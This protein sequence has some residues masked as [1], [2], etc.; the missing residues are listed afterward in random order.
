MGEIHKLLTEHGKAKVVQMD[1]DR[2]VIDAATHY[3]GI[4][5][6]EIGF[7]YS[8]WAQSAL[9][10]KKLADEASW[11]VRTDY[12]TLI[13]QP[14]L[15]AAQAGDPI[16]VGVPYGSR[17]RLICIY[18]QSEALKTNSRE[19]ELGRTLHAW[20]RRLGISIG[21]KSM[22]AVRDQAE[23]I[24]RCRMTFQVKS[25][26]RTGLVNQNILDTAMF[27]D[28]IDG[29]GSFIEQAKLSEMFFE[30][31]KRHPVPIEE[32]AI[33]SLSNNSMAI[34]VYC[35][36][37]YRLHSLDKPTFISWKALHAQFGTAVGLLR[38]FR[39]FFRTTLDLALSV[40]PEAKVT[41]EERGLTLIPSRPPV[42]PKV[43]SLA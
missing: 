21:G 6:S 16:P 5:D 8:G 13:V 40:Y 19:V 33:S 14:G 34:D 39:A 43:V 29:A 1:F 26:N 10:H 9:P 22:T 23:R 12:V 36:L 25:G 24:S 11:Q 37:A 2:R 38:N 15:R 7:L 32:A 4:E 18:L 35:W 28:D 42:S 3:M 30:Q 17:A 41:V 27:V 20:L 31:L